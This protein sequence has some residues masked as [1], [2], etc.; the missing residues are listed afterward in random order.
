MPSIVAE[1]TAG[2]VD[3][4]K[5]LLLECTV[6]DIDEREKNAAHLFLRY[7]YQ[8]TFK[9]RIWRTFTIDANLPIGLI[10]LHTTYLAVLAQ[11]THLYE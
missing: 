3:K 7:L 10:G 6:Q 1:Q 8:R 5:L 2:E 9:V 11:L 4:I